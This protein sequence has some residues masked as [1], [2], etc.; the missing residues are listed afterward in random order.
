MPF[1]KSKPKAERVVRAKLRDGTVKE[2]RYPAYTPPKAPARHEPDSIAALSIAWRRS[3]EWAATGA[4]TKAHRLVYIRD[5]ERLGSERVAD[6][7]R[8]DVLAIRDTIA[9]TRGPGAATAFIKTAAAAFA[10]ALDRGWIEASPIHRIK[11]LPAGEL[12]AWT[13]AEAA[14][15][16]ANLPEHLRRAV[17]LAL[18]TGQRRGDLC[19]MTW[20]DVAGGVL[21]LTQQKTGAALVIPLHPDL[22]AELDAWRRT[23]TAVQILTTTWGRPWDGQ[24]L[25][26]SLATACQKLGM[27]VGLNVHGLRKLAATRLAEAGCSAH[28]IASITGHRSLAMVQHYTKAADQQRLAEAA[29]ARLQTR[30]TKIDK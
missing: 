23:A 20:Q 16:L 27:R 8:R 22:R 3:P 17:V 4:R 6:L 18:H 26:N 9:R 25:S 15:A 5:L 24:Y 30:R 1:R 19:R 13:E 10:W 11:P 12:P 29:V 2:Y 28:E 7:R 21:R 14:H